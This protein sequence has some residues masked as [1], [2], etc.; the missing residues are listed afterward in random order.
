MTDYIPTTWGLRKVTFIFSR[1]KTNPPEPSHEESHESVHRTMTTRR[2]TTISRE[3]SAA[4]EGKREKKK[5][6]KEKKGAHEYR[7]FLIGQ[8]SR[9]SPIHRIGGWLLLSQLSH[10]ESL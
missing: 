10:R 7:H 5:K 9:H 1:N 2:T 4:K 8:M 6:E 3:Q